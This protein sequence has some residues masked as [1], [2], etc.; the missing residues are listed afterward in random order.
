MPGDM[1]RWI[2]GLAVLAHGIGH[3]LF[4]PALAGA[5]KLEADGHS[6]LL[7]GLLG[8]GVTNGLATIAATVALAAFAAAAAGLVGQIGWWRPVALVGAIVSLALVV[9]M[10]DGLPTS[11]AAFAVA[12]DLVVVGAIVAGVGQQEALA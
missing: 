8:D 4:M 2:I 6:W 12:F 7:T 10:W 3:I 5:M 11:S 9:V 1:W